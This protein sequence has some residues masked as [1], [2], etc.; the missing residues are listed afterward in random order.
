[1]VEVHDGPNLI[2]HD[3][4]ET[5]KTKLKTLLDRLSNSYNVG[6]NQTHFV[7]V[8]DSKAATRYIDDA[9]L[10]AKEMI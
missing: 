2:F 9:Q 8:V 10:K 6:G 5:K 7:N 1:V 4:Y 3:R